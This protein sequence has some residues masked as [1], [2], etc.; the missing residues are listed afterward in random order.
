MKLKFKQQ[1]DS[2][3][4]YSLVSVNLLLAKTLGFFLR[5]NH[6]IDKLPANIVF[7]KILGLGSVFMASDAIVAV[8]RKYPQAVL[9]LVCNKG[10]AEGIKP[11]A[12]FDRILVIEDRNMA[13][14]LKS[15]IAVLFQTWKMKK[16]WIVD[17]EVYSKLTTVFA[18]WTFAINRYGFY[19][20]SVWF[21]WNM[22]THNVYFNQF[23]LV[24]ENYH[25]LAEAM[26]SPVGKD[27]CFFP[28][29]DLSLREKESGF[30][31]IAINNTCSELGRERICAPEV[32][33]PVCH[34]LLA[35]TPYRL[36]FTGAPSDKGDNQQFI[37]KYL[38]SYSSENV[39]NIAGKYSFEE[40]YK[41]LFHQCVLL[42]T[43]DT[44]PLHMARKLNVPT[45]SLW[46]PTQPESRI[47]TDSRNS[48]Y[49]LSKSC[50][51]CVHYTD[52]L[53]CGGN[54][55][56]MKDMDPQQIILLLKK[57]IETTASTHA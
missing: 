4:G 14:L 57:M 31:Y 56:C 52:V 43:V 37:E 33:A 38:S 29:F 30:P 3:L 54:N 13:A 6:S 55:T 51:P 22:N 20:G 24:E 1:V 18:L 5:R 40:Y 27:K 42:L 50:S 47:K 41:F 19:L 10:I 9:S 12:L 7:I 16:L 26:G 53:P 36:A 32:L 2:I 48:T 23:V 17:L 45:V 34:W 44:G 46:G 15:S 28:G 11:L 8:K 49:Y 21:R 25:R 39:I 35:N